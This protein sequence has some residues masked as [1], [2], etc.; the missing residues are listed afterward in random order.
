MRLWTIAINFKRPF[1][2]TLSIF[3]PLAAQ[4]RLSKPEMQIRQ[5]RLALFST[6]K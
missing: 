5:M 3:H 6:K 4:I 2:G 1:K